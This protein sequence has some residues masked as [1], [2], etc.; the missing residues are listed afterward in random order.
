MTPFQL[1]LLRQGMRLLGL[2]LVTVGLPQP[3]ADWV[4]EPE[5]VNLVAGLI[6]YAMADTGWLASLMTR[7]RA[8]RGL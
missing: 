6:V 4:G 2:F 5:T 8:W 7:Y 3:I 1:E